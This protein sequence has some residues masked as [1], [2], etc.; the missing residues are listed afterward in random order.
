MQFTFTLKDKLIKSAITES[1][2]C[3]V[4]GEYDSATLKL[5]KAPKVSA[6]ANQIFEDEK[7]QAELTKRMVRLA[8]GLIEDYISDELTYEMDLPG[9]TSLMK[10]CDRVQEQAREQ[11]L[12]LKEAEEV[13]RMV[14]TL[15]KAGFKIVKA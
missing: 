13:K 5:A 8:E 14:A 9:V 1:L 15:E 2:E 12:A 6:L 4:Y 11:A 7:F 10:E 3:S